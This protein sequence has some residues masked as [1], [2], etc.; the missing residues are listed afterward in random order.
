MAGMDD[1]GDRR[2]DILG[3]AVAD[4]SRAAALEMILGAL[5]EHRHLKVAFCNAHTANTASADPGFRQALARFVVLPDGVGVD[6]AARWLGGRSFQANLNGTDL[7]PDLLRTADRPFRIA[8][9]GG[10]KGVAERAADVLAQLGPG[11]AV[12]AV[13]DGFSGP[14]TE[15]EWLADLAAAPADLMLVAMGNPKQELWISAHADGR[16]AAV[17][18]GVGALFDFLAGEVSRAPA[19]VRRLRLEWLWRLMLEPRR[20]FA[21]YVLG[22]PLFLARVLMAR[23]GRPQ[24]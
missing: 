24:A 7:V 9:I 4:M 11:H 22:N 5:R 21:R 1:P 17:V 3:V 18:M 15:A 13:C 8:L 12:M 10:R 6:I 2:Q 16:H 23:W 14:G 20:L 19:P